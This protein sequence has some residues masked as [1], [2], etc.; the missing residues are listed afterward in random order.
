MFTGPQGITLGRRG[1]FK[2]L[3]RQITSVMLL[4]FSFWVSFREEEGD[5]MPQLVGL[6]SL[7]H[8]LLSYLFTYSFVYSHAYFKSPWPTS[9]SPLLY[10]HRILLSANVLVKFCIYSVNF[11]FLYVTIFHQRL[12]L[13]LVNL[14]QFSDI[15]PLLAQ[16]FIHSLLTF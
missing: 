8:R 10:K 11:L 14:Q 12:Y 6:S 9:I 2:A 7:V 13:F 4:S 1:G 15:S 16:S 5:A 3:K